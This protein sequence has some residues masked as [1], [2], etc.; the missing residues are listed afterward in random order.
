MPVMQLLA[1]NEQLVQQCRRNVRKR[2]APWGRTTRF[3]RATRPGQTPGRPR[4]ATHTD[5]RLHAIPPTLPRQP[6]AYASVFVLLGG[7]IA[8]RFVGPALGLYKLAGEF[9][10]PPV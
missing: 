4:G 10:P 3:V 1:S 8:F 9:A 5:T 7:W 2:G 6:A